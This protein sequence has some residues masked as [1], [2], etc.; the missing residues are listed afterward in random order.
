MMMKSLREISEVEPAV[1]VVVVVYMAVVERDLAA[2]VVG[3]ATAVVD[4]QEE[5][6]ILMCNIDFGMKDR[7]INLVFREEVERDDGDE[8]FS[9]KTLNYLIVWT[10]SQLCNR[11]S[12]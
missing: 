1:M 7:I 10:L 5:E 8:G 12:K 3:M 6:K 9:F 4:I 2:V 11:W